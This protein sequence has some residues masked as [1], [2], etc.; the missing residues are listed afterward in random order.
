MKE[1]CTTTALTESDST[2]IW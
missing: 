1:Q 2:N